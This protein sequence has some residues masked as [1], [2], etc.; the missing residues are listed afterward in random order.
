[1]QKYAFKN[2]FILA[3]GNTVQQQNIDKSSHGYY[4][5][6]F[7]YVSHCLRA[8]RRFSRETWKT[9][10]SPKEAKTSVHV[11]STI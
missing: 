6:D 3:F 5:F 10:F 7:C 8:A 2:Y 11:T 1:M 4:M 9:K